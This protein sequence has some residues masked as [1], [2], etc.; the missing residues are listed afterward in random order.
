MPIFFSISYFRSQIMM[1]AAG[2]VYNFT[3]YALLHHVQNHKL[4][5][6]IATVFHNHARYFSSFIRFYQSP[7]FLNGIGSAYFAGYIFTC[8]HC[9]YSNIDML[10][11]RCS[12]NNGIYIC[13]SQ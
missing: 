1:I 3:K 2:S 4:I 8:F 10:F 9:C 7:A 11:P 5:S 13:N 6:A 12:N